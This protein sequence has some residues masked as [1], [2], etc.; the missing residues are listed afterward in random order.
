MPEVSSPKRALLVVDMQVGLFHGPEHPY[1]GERVLANINRLIGR[2]HE[3]GAPVFAVRHTGPA[4]SPIAPGSPLTALVPELAIDTARDIVFDKAQSSS[5]A[6]TRLAE[7]LREAGIGEIVI[8]G[9]KT[10]YCVDTACRAAADH[11]FR[12]VLVTDAHTCMDTPELPAKRIVAH[13]NA[14]LGGPFATLTTT[15]ACVF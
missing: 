7:W 2:A 14:T 6:G 5:F 15:D 3:A 10:Q 11:G 1:D 9:M 4:G 8:A 12:A 13:H